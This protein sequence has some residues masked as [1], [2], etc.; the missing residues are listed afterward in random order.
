FEAL[1]LVVAAIATEIGTGHE[2][3]LTRGR[4]AE[5]LRASYALPGIFAPVQIGGRWLMDGALVNPVP[6]SAAR[7]LGAR[8]VIGVNLNADLIGR[9][10]TI[11]SFGADEAEDAA[12]EAAQG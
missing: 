1:P 8:V 10:A 4:L 5:A 7:A 3:W 12:A 2:I 9:G 6:I 11:S